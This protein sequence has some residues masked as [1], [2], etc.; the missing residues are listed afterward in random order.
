MPDNFSLSQN[1]PNPFNPVTNFKYSIPKDTWVKISV[2]NIMGQKVAVL[3][4]S[5]KNVGNY[6]MV[7]NANSLPSGIYYLQMQTNE[8]QTIRKMVFLK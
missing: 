5:Y 7:F 6:Q 8:F 2:F 4:D 3:V 1:Y